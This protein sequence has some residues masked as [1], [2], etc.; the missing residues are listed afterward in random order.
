MI[1]FGEQGGEQLLVAEK[2]RNDEVRSNADQPLSF[3]LI[4]FAAFRFR[5]RHPDGQAAHFLDVLYLYVA[6]P[7]SEEF[8]AAAVGGIFGWSISILPWL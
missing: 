8:L 2:V 4:H 7:K 1:S 3:P 5:S 6:V